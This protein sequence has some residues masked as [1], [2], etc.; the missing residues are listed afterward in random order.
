M[1]K[2]PLVDLYA[3]YLSI[4][5]EIDEAIANTIK[6]SSFIGGSV[7]EFENAFAEYANIPYVIAC[8]NGTDSIEILLKAYGIKEGDEVIVPS[9][10]WISTSEAVAG[11]G[12]TPVFVDIEP[13]YF[14][15]DVS[16]IENAIT[17]R[18][19]A[20]IPVHLYGHPA[21]MPAIMELSKEHGLIVIEDCAQAHGA[22]IDGKKIGT[23]GHAA[24]FS[25]YPGK[26]LGAY[27]DAGCMATADPAIAEK[28]RMIAHH[29][30]KGKHNHQ[31]EG[32]NSRLDGIQA[33]I[34]LAKL[35][36]LEKWTEQRIE[37]AAFYYS[38]LKDSQVEIPKTKPGYRHVFHLYVV[39]VNERQNVR[40]KLLYAGIETAIHYPSPLPFLPCYASRGFKPEQFPVAVANQSHIL[41]IPMYPELTKADQSVVARHLADKVLV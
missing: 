37:H 21:D 17:A 15:I 2:I 36:H 32:R 4:K 16:L 7:K 33:A 20:I 23:F 9:C 24:S 3:Q 29:G 41:S 26:N 11:V 28:A 12:A 14:T 34:L 30:Q 1:K 38:L 35:P 22:S 19:R 39:K 27:G 25:F 31:I 8:G 40:D 18:T 10:T 6:N 5:E 13:N